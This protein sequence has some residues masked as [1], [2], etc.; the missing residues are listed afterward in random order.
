MCVCVCV[1]FMFYD[2]LFYS[3]VQV[4]SNTKL[5]GAKFGLE[6]RSADFLVSASSIAPDCIF[7]IYI[8]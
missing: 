5:E 7:K 1:C 2:D 8:V 3:K 4:A 6:L